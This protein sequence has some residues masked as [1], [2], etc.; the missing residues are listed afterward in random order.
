M[1]LL[2]NDKILT[3]SSG[4][5]LKNIQPRISVPWADPEGDRGSGPNLELS[6]SDHEPKTAILL[7]YVNHKMALHSH[8]KKNF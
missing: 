2:V 1:Q 4:K 8:N 3:L 5:L 6:A 7:K